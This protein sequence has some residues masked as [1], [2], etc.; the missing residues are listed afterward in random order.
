M[1][2][3]ENERNLGVVNNHI[4]SKPGEKVN[5]NNDMATIFVCD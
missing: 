4:E 2:T 1:E 5:E 3:K